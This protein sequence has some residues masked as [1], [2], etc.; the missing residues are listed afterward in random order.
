MK[1]LKTKSLSYLVIGITLV[2]G[3]SAK[4]YATGSISGTVTNSG[5]GYVAGAKVFA[6]LD[7]VCVDLDTTESAGQY[8]ITGLEA[9]T[10]EVRVKADGYELRVE[11]N[12]VVTNNNNTVKNI[13]NLTVEGIITGRVVQPDETT[14]IADAYVSADDDEGFMR[15][16]KTDA[17][18]NYTIDKLRAATYT[19]TV[20]YGVSNYEFPENEDIVVTAGSTTS[21]VV[22]VG[23]VPPTGKISGTVTESDGTTAIE[24]ASVFA[25][26]S[27]EE[28]VA[29]DATDSTGN[30]E[31][32]ALPTG[33]YSVTASR[34]T[35]AKIAVISNVS[36]TD[37]QTTD[38]DLA[39]PGGSISGTVKNSS[40]TA[41]EGATLTAMK[42]GK[43]YETTSAA[44]GTYIIE[45]LPAGTY[46]VT[47]DPN[48]N[49]Y[50]AS[51]IDDVIVVANQE[52]SNQDF[53]LGQ[54]G[55]ISG[56]I[57]NTSQEPI[58]GAVVVAVEPDDAENDPTAAFIPAITDASGNYTIA[59]L[60]TGTYT[61][62]VSANNYVS[63]TETSVSVTVGQ[64][65]SG[66]NFSLGTSGGAISGT[67]YEADGQTPIENAMVQC[68]SP[69]KS[70]ASAMSDGNGDYS[71][72][73]LQAGTYEVYASADGYEMETLDNIV[74][75][76]TGEN[77]G[78]DFT[79][80][81]E[82]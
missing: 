34:S 48:E 60:R 41:I 16:A 58:E 25:T 24:G 30:Y 57:T 59:H 29:F 52:T 53:S 65:T 79:L 4:S 5:S 66:K 74:V 73:L 62:C 45:A 6:I 21:N 19:V 56:T 68:L 9:G 44:D 36:V 43:V 31:L 40:Q 69:G 11:T 77:S 54:D 14:G 7:G 32:S 23:V 33:S 71:L 28:V 72:P 78:N 42:D 10:Y 61:I 47:V 64:T 22:L 76:G 51:K 15:F 82:E 49:D 3:M 80:D 17:G 13:T 46:Q 18:G 37:G 20:L 39:V 67:V 2:S 75:T 27:A 55:K 70:F 12:V 81:E 35:G 38:Q 50:V 63:D 26:D 1:S 8:S